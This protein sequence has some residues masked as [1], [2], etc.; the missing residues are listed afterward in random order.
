MILINKEQTKIEHLAKRLGGIDLP[1]DKIFKKPLFEINPALVVADPANGPGATKVRQSMEFP[2]VFRAQLKSGEDVEIRYCT[3]RQPDPKF[4]GQT[5]KFAPRM[6]EFEGKAEFIADDKDKAVYFWL[7]FYNKTSPFRQE[8][9]PYEYALVDDDARATELIAGI[10]LRSKATAYAAG[11]SGSE[12]IIIAKGMKIPGASTM[13]PLMV[14]AQL[15]QY[16]S[17]KPAEFL[18]KAES[19]VN[20]IEGLIRDSIDKGIFILENVFN[21]KRWRWGMGVK[22]GEVIVEMSASVPDEPQALITHISQNIQEFLPVLIDTAKTI[23]AR[24]NLENKLD[25]IDVFAQ[26]RGNTPAVNDQEPEKEV[27]NS[28]DQT[29]LDSGDD[30]EELPTSFAECQAYLYTKIGKKTP[31]LAS[32]LNKGIEAGTITKDNIAMILEEMKTN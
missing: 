29:D 2:A 13:E 26:L 27:T 3:N 12:M 28:N 21:S 8:G 31:A 19:Q 6:V 24:V 7:H 20:H 15:M 22:K 5:E 18:N 4:M 25:N 30:Q 16:A 9:V 14:K 32:Q 1:I 10:T 23:N 11:L 17:D